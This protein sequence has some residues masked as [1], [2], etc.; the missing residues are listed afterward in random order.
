VS[1]RGRIRTGSLATPAVPGR[2]PGSDEVSNSAR[3]DFSP[4][5]GRIVTAPIWVALVTA[6]VMPAAG[7]EPFPLTYG[8]WDES[9]ARWS[10]DGS[11]I[12]S[13]SNREGNTQ[14]RLMQIPGARSRE[15]PSVDRHFLR[16]TGA[17]HLTVLDESARLTPARVTVTGNGRFYG[18]ARLAASRRIRSQRTPFD[19]LF[20]H[21]R[22]DTIG[23]RGQR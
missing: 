22:R 19:A 13:I 23:A 4:D 10:P 18:P 21:R 12:A 20:P 17:I 8:D 2:R 7:G 14:L 5:G 16:P 9:N 1:N 11:L 3:P 6:L 15:L